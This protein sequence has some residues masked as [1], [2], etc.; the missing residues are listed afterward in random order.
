[1]AARALAFLLAAGCGA[2]TP[3]PA[4]DPAPPPAPAVAAG[5]APSAV[6]PDL[7]AC[8]PASV[9]D[10]GGSVE[11]TARADDGDEELVLLEYVPHGD[12]TPMSV[13]SFRPVLLRVQGDTC[14]S[15]L[16]ERT[17]SFDLRVYARPPVLRE[18]LR[19]SAAWHAERV[20][21]TA[22]YS[23]LLAEGYGGTLAECADRSELGFCVDPDRAEALRAIGVT[24]VLPGR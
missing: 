12:A 24:V 4:V 19:E 17:D 1:M 10:D 2:S 6:D 5:D 20:G 18:L 8:V 14:E 21:G 13:V 7:E 3:S 16:P 23:E 15:L 11:L 9:R 22:A